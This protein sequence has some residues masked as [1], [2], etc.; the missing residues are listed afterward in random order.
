MQCGHG[1][2]G[3]AAEHH[4]G[5]AGSVSGEVDA[6]GV[7]VVTIRVEAEAFAQRG[8]RDRHP[9]GEVVAVAG[10]GILADPDD[11]TALGV[12]LDGVERAARLARSD[13][14]RTY[15]SHARPWPR[16]FYP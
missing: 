3:S 12:L 1:T 13:F 8:N 4:A 16:R 2:V 6:E 9:D 11:A 5:G 7:G 14:A 10:A 15:V